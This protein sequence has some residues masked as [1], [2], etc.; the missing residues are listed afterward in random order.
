MRV[1][2]PI[3]TEIVFDD[4]SRIQSAMFDKNLSRTFDKRGY[5]E[6]NIRDGTVSVLHGRVHRSRRR[7]ENSQFRI[8]QLR[9]YEEE[10]FPEIVERLVTECADSGEADLFPM[11]ELLAVVL[12]AK[13]AG[14]DCNMDDRQALH[15]LVRYVE[16]FSQM[17]AIIDAK[18]PDAVRSM[19]REA[20]ADFSEQFGEPSLRRRE[21]LL[22]EFHAGGLPESELPHDILTNLLRHRDD[23]DMAFSGDFLIIRE[24]ATYLQGGTHTSSQTLINTLDLLFDTTASHPEYWARL[25]S[26]RAFAQRCVHEALRL[27]PTTPRAKRRAEHPTTIDGVDVPEGSMVVLDLYKAN[28]DPDVFGRDADEFVPDRE[29]NG[30]VQRWGLSFGAGPHICPG[31]SVAGGLPQGSPSDEIGDEHLFGLVAGMVQAVAQRAPRRHPTKPQSRDLRTERFTRW[32]EYWVV[33]DSP[34]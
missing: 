25:R 8:D 33:F 23:P 7:I 24:A 15:D 34:S 6:G 1:I 17:S 29:I 11:G 14:F 3:T 19:V 22:E 5:D 30:R 9:Q 16:A 26:D 4:L 13:R 12:A 2:E 28:R 18:D 10:F 20:L 27:R 21:A 31:R 32:Q